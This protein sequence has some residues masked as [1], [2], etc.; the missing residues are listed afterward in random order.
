MRSQL[1]THTWKLGAVAAGVAGL[2]AGGGLMTAQAAQAPTTK[3]ARVTLNPDRTHPAGPVTVAGSG[4]PADT[5]VTIRL[6]GQTVGQ[7][8]SSQAGTLDTVIEVPASTKPGSYSL[9]ATPAGGR[10]SWTGL[11]VRTNWAMANFDPGATGVNPW[12]NV[13]NRSNVASLAPHWVQ[14]AGTD[15]NDTSI[16]YSAP[17]VINGSVYTSYFSDENEYPDV[18]VSLSAST[19]AIQWSSSVGP[20]DGPPVVIN[21]NLYVSTNGE[22]FELN[23]QTGA[24]EADLGGVGGPMMYPVGDMLYTSAPAAVNTATNTVLWSGLPAGTQKSSDASY[25]DGMMF[26]GVQEIGPGSTTVA[27]LLA[28]NASTGAVV[29]SVPDSDN[30][31]QTPTIDNGMVFYSDDASTY[32]VNEQTGAPVWTATRPNANNLFV[33]PAVVGNGVVYELGAGLGGYAYNETTGALIWTNTTLQAKNYFS[34]TLTNGILYVANPNGLYAVDPSSGD[35]LSL[36]DQYELNSLA[37]V[38]GNV[39]CG[40]DRAEGFVEFA[41]PS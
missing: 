31:D 32:A 40:T 1:K 5:P 25:D 7:A 9:S 23:A 10:V 27:E 41:L 8:T 37:I 14:T 33:T 38:N 3:T 39:Y 21:G 12:E 26:M 17:A 24:I 15:T 2:M 36:N 30:L 29:W 11:T 19:G 35:I 34:T 18:L 22:L 13:L 28:L 4:F 6:A 16:Q 20:A